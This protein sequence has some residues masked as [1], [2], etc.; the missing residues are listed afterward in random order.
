MQNFPPPTS[1]NNCVELNEPTVS[2]PSSPKVLPSM[3]PELHL[4]NW[5]L[6]IL[7]LTVLAERMRQSLLLVLYLLQKLQEKRKNKEV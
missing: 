2:Y 7:L 4:P 5:L 1:L 6:A 3:R